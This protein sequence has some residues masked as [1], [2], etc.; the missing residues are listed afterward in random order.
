[1]CEGKR[2]GGGWVWGGEV[3]MVIITVVDIKKVV[4][5]K[6]VYITK[7]VYIKKFVI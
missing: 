6:G 3:Q 7:V 5:Q 4:I 1:M 2:G